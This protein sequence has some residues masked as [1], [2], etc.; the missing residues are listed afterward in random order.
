[1]KAIVSAV[2]AAALLTA[3]GCQQPVADRGAGMPRGP[4][5]AAPRAPLAY[6]VDE[7]RCAKMCPSDSNPC[8][9]ISYKM[10]DGRCAWE[11][12]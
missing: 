5:A 1:M 7:R 8:D 9:P 11:N 2:A 3:A 6:G 10:A 12:F 4:V